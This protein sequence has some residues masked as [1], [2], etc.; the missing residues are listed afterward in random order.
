MTGIKLNIEAEKK[1]EARDKESQKKAVKERGKGKLTAGRKEGP[2]TNL[3]PPN[4]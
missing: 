2:K 3:A 4:N 1:S